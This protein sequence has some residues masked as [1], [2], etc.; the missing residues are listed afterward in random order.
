MTETMPETPASVKKTYFSRQSGLTIRVTKGQRVTQ[1][2]GTSFRDN[3]KI[4]EFNP[5]NA[6]YGMYE[7]EDPEEIAFLDRRCIKEKDV[8]D[9]TAYNDLLME[10]EKKIEVLRGQVGDQSRTISEQS[11][12]IEELKAKLAAKP[13]QVQQGRPQ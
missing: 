10:P 4:V 1:A 6:F 8:M 3:E 2:D 9:P 5:I 12:L 7:T 11:R 13:A